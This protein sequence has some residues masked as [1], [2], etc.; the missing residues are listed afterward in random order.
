[1]IFVGHTLHISHIS[2]SVVVSPDS[3]FF[4]NDA[5][6]RLFRPLVGVSRLY[7]RKLLFLLGGGAKL[8]KGSHG[9]KVGESLLHVSG[10]ETLGQAQVNKGQNHI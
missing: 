8:L 6:L 3:L 2:N 5:S 4:T 10:L 1:M 7:L 9:T